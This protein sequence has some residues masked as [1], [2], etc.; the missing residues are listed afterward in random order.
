MAGGYG[1]DAGY[2]LA[3]RTAGFQVHVVSAQ[4]YGDIA[5]WEMS[6]ADG[7]KD[8]LAAGELKVERTFE[9]HPYPG[10]WAF[11]RL[12]LGYSYLLD[13]AVAF[14]GV[15]RVLP[16][17]YTLYSDDIAGRGKRATTVYA[18]ELLSCEGLVPRPWDYANPY[19]Q[20]S[21]I[22]GGATLNG[23][24]HMLPGAPGYLSAKCRFAFA[25][26][27]Y[28]VDVADVVMPRLSQT[29]HPDEGSWRRY[30]RVVPVPSAKH[31]TFPAGAYRW[32]ADNAS[33]AQTVGRMLQYSDVDV[34][35]FKVPYVP[36]GS[37]EAIGKVNDGDWNP[38]FV[39]KDQTM[40]LLGTA[41]QTEINA[42]GERTYT[43]VYRLR[44]FV[45]DD[46]LRHHN[47]F[48]RFDN[49]EIKWDKPRT[50]LGGV[51]RYVFDKYDFKKLFCGP[52]SVF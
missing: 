15:H 18:T 2:V 33:T 43:I 37:Y 17:R 52:F 6:T 19:N 11:T 49:N 42:L 29:Q 47:F 26:P 25:R 8:S 24:T 50:T 9:V 31:I 46:L 20:H 51:T 41:V 23:Y 14:A 16:Q 35:W 7:P 4:G 36:A 27:P 34:T 13:P 48:F 40:L 12:M 44:R 10:R 1:Y 39:F 32:E 21:N 3:K 38:G 30:V 28:P 22:P 45:G 5:Y